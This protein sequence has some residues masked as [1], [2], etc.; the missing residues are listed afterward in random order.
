MSTLPWNEP[1]L[2][3]LRG[4]ALP[5]ALLIHGARGV[6]KLAL[7]ESL[8]QMVL[9]EAAAAKKPCGACEGCRWFAAGSHPDFRRLEPEALA[10]AAE[11]G[12]EGEAPAQRGKPSVV[13]KIEQVRAL[14]NF[15]Y[16]G[17]HRSGRRVAL[18]HPAEDMNPNAANALLKSLEEPPAAAMFILV[19]HR[20]ARLP[21]TIRSRCVSMPVRLPPHEAAVQWLA[22][23]GVKEPERWLAFAGGAPLRAA[24][25][26]AEAEF[27]D[28]V[29]R[30]VSSRADIAIEDRESLEAFA[31]ALQKVA[32]DRAFSASGVPA[33]YRT[34]SIAADPRSARAWLA[35]ARQ[36]GINRAFARH[37]VNARLFAAEM[38][39]TMP[40]DGK[41]Q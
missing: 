35:Y 18:V 19:A 15:L 5:H 21:P 33:K 12:E 2:E 8:A 36:M 20:P 39:A 37:P 7:A 6:G 23:E 40:A 22:G 10:P 14:A 17:S 32:L 26:A 24:A 11:A 16:V 28:R 27:L 41:S 30:A 29:L 3:R 34:G 9:C 31:E 25:L 13:I 1:L 4:Q 38:L